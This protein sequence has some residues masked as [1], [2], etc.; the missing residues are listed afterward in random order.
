MVIF[1]IVIIIALAAWWGLMQHGAASLE[2]LKETGFDVDHLIGTTTK[3]ALDEDQRKLAYVGVTKVL[4][5][6]YEQVLGWEAKVVERDGW[7]NKSEPAQIH[8]L[9]VYVKDEQQPEMRVF[10]D[11][12]G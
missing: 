2:H 8:Y 3:L 7:A 12:C 6:D 5:Y 4:V 9:V 11:I 10:R 1:L